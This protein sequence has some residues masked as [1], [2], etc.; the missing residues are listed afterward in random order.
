ML[1][2]KKTR[3][4]VTEFN[5]ID[6]IAKAYASGTAIKAGTALGIKAKAVMDVGGLVSDD[7]IIGLVKERI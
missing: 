5:T 6:V 1:N 4:K 7:I 3:T 2:L